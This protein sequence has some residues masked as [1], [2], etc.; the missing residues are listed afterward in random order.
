MSVESSIGATLLVE[1]QRQQEEEKEESCVLSQWMPAKSPSKAGK[2]LPHLSGGATSSPTVFS[3]RSSIPHPEAAPRGQRCLLSHTF[4]PDSPTV[5]LKAGSGLETEA[6]SSRR[7]GQVSVHVGWRGYKHAIM[8]ASGGE[9]SREP[10]HPHPLCATLLIPDVSVLTLSFLSFILSLGSPL[11]QPMSTQ[12]S[13]PEFPSDYAP[14]L[15]A[16]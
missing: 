14:R 3:W 9:A 16:Q 15:L 11:S 1:V 5:F 2:N 6:Q 12:L 10:D 4:P 8:E 7:W 13:A